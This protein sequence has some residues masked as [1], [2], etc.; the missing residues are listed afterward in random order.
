MKYH[1]FALKYEKTKQKSY[2]NEIPRVFI[3]VIS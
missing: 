3:L 1:S 2:R